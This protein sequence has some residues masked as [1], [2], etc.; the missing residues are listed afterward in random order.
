[1][2]SDGRVTLILY[3]SGA[4]LHPS[5]RIRELLL[6]VSN[7]VSGQRYVAVRADRS[8]QAPYDSLETLGPRIGSA[9]GLSYVAGLPSPRASV[10][11]W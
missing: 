3:M 5:P 11:G 1:M 7:R 6:A 10:R 9:T 2:R 8:R 4:L